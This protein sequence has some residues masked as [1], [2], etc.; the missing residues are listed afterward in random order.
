[1]KMATEIEVCSRD[2]NSTVIGTIKYGGCSKH[3]NFITGEPYDI[4]HSDNT[5]ITGMP[6]LN[7]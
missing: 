1:M 3:Y 6:K 2:D 5:N 4:S 7:N